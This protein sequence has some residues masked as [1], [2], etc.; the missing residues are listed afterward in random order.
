MQVMA[1]MR[2]ET[3]LGADLLIPPGRSL[4][5][6]E[7]LRLVGA[8]DTSSVWMFRQAI[9]D[10]PVPCRTVLDLSALSFID[11]AGLGAIVGGIRRIRELGGDLNL[12]APNSSINRVFATTGLD[13]VAN[14][15]AN[16]EDAVDAHR[17]AVG[18]QATTS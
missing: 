11:S 1:I 9:A 15:Y 3:D 16:V 8:I 18:I 14:I 5:D 7:V 6:C 2:F 13:R 17:Q 12:A 4:G 10:L